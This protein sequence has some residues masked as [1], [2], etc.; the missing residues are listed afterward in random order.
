MLSIDVKDTPLYTLTPC[1]KHLVLCAR[2]PIRLYRLGKP[3]TCLD[4]FMTHW[5]FRYIRLDLWDVF[6]GS[7]RVDEPNQVSGN[8]GML[9]PRYCGIILFRQLDDELEK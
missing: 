8:S 9:T 7:E 4:L 5:I 6:T 1:G 2:K 3:C